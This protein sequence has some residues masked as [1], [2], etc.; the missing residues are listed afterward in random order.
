MATLQFKGKNI[1][2]NHHLS[3]P[4]HSLEEDEKLS[5]EPDKAD[6]N[7]LIEGD[8]LLGLKS[9][10]PTHT[11]KVKCIY[12]DP[13]YNTG[14]EDWVYSDNVNSPLIKDWLGKEVGADD[15]TKHDKWL[16]MMTPRLKLLKELLSDDG[17]I[18]I[19]IDD[20]EVHH[21]KSLLSEIFGEENFLATL[22]WENKEGGGSSDSKHF[23]IKHEYI[24]V[25]SKDI[26]KC[27]I[28]GTDISN[29]DRYREKDEHF[30]ERGPYYRQKLGMSSIQYS[31]SLDYEI[32]A[33]DGTKIFPSDNANGEKACWRW[34]K[35]KYEWGVKN[36]FIVIKE[37]SKGVPTVYTKQYLKVDNNNMPIDR[38]HRPIG[39][40]SDFSSTQATKAIKS[41]FPDEENFFSYPKPVELIKYLLERVDFNNG[42]IVLDSFAG[43]GT[44]A[45]AVMELN[46][47]D[48][49]DRK[50]V[51]VQMKEDSED[52]PNKN[53]AKS[54]TQKRL[55]R[56]IETHKDGQQKL[57]SKYWNSV[58][59]TYQKVG[60]S[61]DPQSMLEGDLPSYEELAKYVYYLAFG[62]AHKKT[63]DIDPKK[64]Y[65]GK[66]GSS[67]IYLIYQQDA[68]KLKH[69]ALNLEIAEKMDKDSRKI[70]Y[71]PACF[72]DS[73][74]LKEFNINF[75]SI[76]YN[77]FELREEV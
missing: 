21:L 29:R 1:I 68:E 45:Q 74:Y 58:G 61:I 62:K 23:R 77:L 19:S 15:L 36:D 20:N 4:Y 52:E 50:F 33:P 63:S 72:L 47:K 12:I 66:E 18:F 32:E 75:V 28:I 13:P 11:G 43:S 3:V 24:L 67:E 8:N 26:S 55:V 14:K 16:C 34:S 71:A 53:I 49:I 10:L 6:G 37:D 54:I 22:V 51:L 56:V 42:D 17:L 27:N 41:L 35:E 39:I 5:Y 57:S 9:L 48:D 31:K 30:E 59:F 46:A 73:E 40:I 69:M 60:S 25:F 7:L 65:V 70:V 2:W 38:S 64:F 76:P 44:T